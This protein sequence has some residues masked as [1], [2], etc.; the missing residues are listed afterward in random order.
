MRVAFT[1]AGDNASAEQLSSFAQHLE[2]KADPGG[3]LRVVV[4]REPEARWLGDPVTLVTAVL[5]GL[6]AATELTLRLREWRQRRIGAGRG[7]DGILI[8]L[9]GELVTPDELIRRLAA[10]QDGDTGNGPSLDSDV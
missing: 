9:D 1:A 4:S 5:S 2:A 8:H 3:A 6:T 7:T 10:Q